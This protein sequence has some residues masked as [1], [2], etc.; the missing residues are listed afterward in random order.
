MNTKRTRRPFIPM[1]ALSLCLLFLGVNGIIGGYLM[2]RDPNGA[3]MGMPVSDLAQT[4]FQDFVIPGLILI[5]VWGGGSLLALLGLW[6]R[7]QWSLLNI[8]SRWTHEH[9]AWALSLV[10][11]LALLV[12]LT[13]Q[14][15]TLPNVAPIQF[16]LYVLAILLV[17]LPL[18]PG[19]RRYYRA[20][21]V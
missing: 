5:I 1:L 21:Q 15:L 4:P 2:L 9:W 7:P 19:M 11:G 10:L 20:G 17:L 3:P 12:W 13:V 14:V 18:L 8:T 6:L 16:I